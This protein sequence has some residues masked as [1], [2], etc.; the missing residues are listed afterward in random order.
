MKLN[1]LRN[2]L[3]LCSVFLLSAMTF[4]QT[5]TLRG[6]VNDVN[7]EPIFGA[8]ILLEGQEKGAKSDVDGT[9]RLEGIKAGTYNVVIKA[10]TYKPQTKS[11]S[12]AANE[13]KFETIVL[14]SEVQ[15]AEETVVIGYG[16]TRTSDLTGAA[17]VIN[18][19]NFQK[20][21]LSSPEQLLSGKVAGL[22]IN[23][24]DGA[25]GSGSTIR[26]RGGTSIN[27]SNDPLIVVDGVPLDNGGIA[28]AANP[29][30]LINPNDIES[31]VVLKDA[32]ATAIF[33][34]RGANG[35]ILITT[36]KGKSGKSPLQVTFDTKHSLSTV[37]KYADVMS[38]DEFRQLITSNGTPNQIALLGNGNTDWQ[39]VVFR[40]AYIMD[41]NASFTGGIK[42]LP[43]RLSYG[44]RLENGL[45]LNDKFQRTGLSLNLSPSFF[46]NSLT[47]ELNQRLVQTQS[48]FAN[49]GALG[50]AYFDPTQDV[51][52]NNAAYGGYYE[53]LDSPSNLP[54][55]LAPR[56]PLGLIKQREDRSAVNRYIGNLTLT[57][58][59]PFFKMMK[60]SMNVG[61]DQSEG[62]GY[63]NQLASS[64]SGYFTQGSFSRYRS[65]K[66]NKLIG[67]NV[68]YNNGEK[69]SK[70]LIDGTLGYTY[71][72]WYT[73][74]PNNPTYN[75]AGDSIIAPATAFPFYTKNA[76]LSFYARGIYTFNDRIVLNAAVR[77]DGSSRFSPDTRWGLFPSVSA[78][79][80][81]SK[82][83]FMSK[84]KW[85][86][87]LKLRGGFGVTGQQDGIGDYAYIGNYF[88]GATTAQ[89]AFGGQYYTVF[90]PD[91]FDAN[92]KWEE[93]ESINFGVDFGF[94]KDRISASVDVYRKNTSDLLAVVNV[95][96]GTN[97]TNSILTN[98]GSMQNQGI[99]FSTN[100]GIIAK[101]NLRFDVAA[102][103]TF[104]QNKI[105]GLTLIEDPNST[106]IFVGGISGGIGNTVQIQQ[107]GNP[108][109][110]YFVY[111]Q[112]Y[113]AAG[114]P[115]EVGQPKDPN[116]PG[117]GNYTDLD[118]FEDA[119]GDGIINVDDRYITR[120]AA[121]KW[122]LGTTLNLTYK[123]WFASATMRSELGGTIYNNIHSNNATFQS[124]NG[125]LG[126]LNNLST[127]Y[128]EEEFQT[129]TERQLLSDHYLE[130]ANF[131]RLD[132]MTLGYRF[133][134]LPISG[135]SFGLTISGVIQNV[136]VITKY[137]GLD[138]E[139][140]GGIDN[141]IYPR[142]RVYSLN[143]TFDI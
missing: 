105:T 128:N 107:V 5:A 119:N 27:A 44:H 33:G 62:T 121:P 83:D 88:E 50:A 75:E 74:S 19:K 82:Y 60:V 41:N 52:S 98:V 143:L 12:F 69:K 124:V 7:G 64:A 31:F 57:Y 17:T 37:A 133:D 35:V 95:P 79:W 67:A 38:G 39:K 20:G 123:K 96:A 89:Y 129:T 4:G 112:K 56:N 30:A 3:T 90:R 26:M 86:N 47:V 125:P 109:F 130:K 127:L 78:A 113:D 81:L 122:F 48:V 59:L 111:R 131:F 118:A 63:V 106:G 22:K 55:T 53:W 92:L 32:S 15:E 6:I 126:F 73:S 71:Q 139:I 2:Y 66:G 138:P 68:N 100:I 42:N 141:N 25:P 102:N 101:K 115:I 9:F 76:L 137:S 16:T 8:S 140:G 18:E 23:S 72:D 34:S 99:E 110:S 1:I 51:Y 134:K 142:P 54:N 120:Q 43:Y 70:H 58:R 108:I 103:A 29:L 13:V 10:L 116:N 85:M 61:T 93:T 14:E 45:L 80:I 136:F 24:N 132:Y 65:T 77:R 104:N 117:A 40:N 87:L 36:K 94:L 11:L 28:G 135:H 49:R 21:S 97:F 46:K 114:K 91:G 84:A